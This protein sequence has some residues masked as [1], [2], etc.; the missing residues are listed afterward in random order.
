M[1]QGIKTFNPKLKINEYNQQD[2][3]PSTIQEFCWSFRKDNT[4]VPRKNII[5]TLSKLRIA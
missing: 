5:S 4:I 1:R 3:V 2:P